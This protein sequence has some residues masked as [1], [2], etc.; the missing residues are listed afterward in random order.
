MS[1][2]L[3]HVLVPLN[4]SRRSALLLGEASRRVLVPRRSP[5]ACLPHIILFSSAR[6]ASLFVGRDA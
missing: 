1:C 2:P 3:P 6:P 4:L 5:P